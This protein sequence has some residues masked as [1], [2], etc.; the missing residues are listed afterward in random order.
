LS[1]QYASEQKNRKGRAQRAE[2]KLAALSAK[3][4]ELSKKGSIVNGQKM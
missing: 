2:Q 3:I 4:E 1:E